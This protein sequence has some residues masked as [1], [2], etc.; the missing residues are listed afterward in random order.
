[1]DY[2]NAKSFPKAKLAKK[3]EVFAFMR[4][5]SPFCATAG[6]FNDVITGKPVE[7]VDWGWYRRGGWQWSMNGRAGVASP[8]RGKGPLFCSL[9][10]VRL[11]AS[12]PRRRPRTRAPA[13]CRTFRRDTYLG[14]RTGTRWQQLQAAETCREALV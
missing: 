5:P 8:R 11:S 1:M 2:E 10:R 13:P 6:Y 12:A 4:E 3:N 14:R 7:G 9:D